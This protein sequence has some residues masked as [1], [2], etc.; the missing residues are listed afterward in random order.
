MK[1][2]GLIGGIG[3]ASTAIYYDAIT[4]RISERRAGHTG[5][6]I[7][8]SIDEHDIYGAVERK[9]WSLVAQILTK[10][11]QTLEKDK[12]D[13]LLICS[14][15]FHKFAPVVAKS[16]NVPLLH[17]L[18]PIS[19]IIDGAGYKKIGLIGT[20]I[21]MTE[22]FYTDYLL[23]H[24][25][26]EE[27]LVPVEREKDEVNQIIFDELLL[28]IVTERSKKRLIEIVRSLQK[29]GAECIILGCTELSLILMQEDLDLPVLDSTM[30][31]AQYAA[32]RM[33]E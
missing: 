11:A 6:L 3:C 33:I 22:T 15:L 27:V 4:K 18:T 13:F 7:L 9:E 19:K 16:C 26:A 10:A 14:N 28:R 20:R 21:T 12:V 32:D 25:K 24:S 31:H 2:L 1:T 17:I 5:Y 30:L 8:Y 29:R 23:A